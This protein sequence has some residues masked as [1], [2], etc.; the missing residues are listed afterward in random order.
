MDALKKTLELKFDFIIPGHGEI[1]NKVEVERMLQF[2][3]IMW[4]QVQKLR[5]EGVSRDKIIEQVH[6]HINYYPLSPGEE[7]IQITLFDEAVGKLY[8]QMGKA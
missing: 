3:K 2:F 7:Q 1:N 5:R 4:D 8:D 6:D